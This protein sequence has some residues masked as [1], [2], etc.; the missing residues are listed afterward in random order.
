MRKEVITITLLVDSSW[1]VKKCI[2]GFCYNAVVA[3]EYAI[4]DRLRNFRVL[5]ICYGERR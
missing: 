1:I 2:D 4:F 5:N 3:G